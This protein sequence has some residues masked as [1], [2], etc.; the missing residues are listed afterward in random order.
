MLTALD[1]LKDISARKTA[2]LKWWLDNDPDVSW[3]K[4]AG[5]LKDIDDGMLG[6]RILSEHCGKLRDTCITYKKI[7]A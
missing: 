4:L 3:N 1:T 7:L 2:M 5:S 6:K